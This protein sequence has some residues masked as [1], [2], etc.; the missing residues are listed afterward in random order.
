MDLRVGAGALIEC[1]R[2]KRLTIPR[3]V[4]PVNARVSPGSFEVYTTIGVG[5]RARLPFRVFT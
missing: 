4:L 5:V 1:S 2:G 3:A